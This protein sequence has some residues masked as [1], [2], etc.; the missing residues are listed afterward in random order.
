MIDVM[1]RGEARR[2]KPGQVG[3]PGFAWWYHRRLR[4]DLLEVVRSFL[5]GLPRIGIV[6]GE[7]LRP[8]PRLHLPDP[9]VA[10][11][12]A[13]G[14]IGERHVGQEI[15]RDVSLAYDPSGI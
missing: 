15:L 4:R 10:G 2:A 5:H 3:R 6:G 11:Q 1:S 13:G 8:F 12:D 7:E 14:I 9:L